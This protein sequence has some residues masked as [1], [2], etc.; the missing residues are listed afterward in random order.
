MITRFLNQV[1]WEKVAIKAE[2]QPSQMAVLCGISLR[3][4]ERHFAR[5]FRQT[6]KLWVRVFR[7]RLAIQLLTAGYS[8]KEVVARLHFGSASH[9]CHDFRKAYPGSPRKTAEL[10]FRNEN[11]ANR[12]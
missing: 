11:V 2:F 8:N 7:C 10:L 12:Q 9:F 6:P 4:L 5:V 1:E 3:Q